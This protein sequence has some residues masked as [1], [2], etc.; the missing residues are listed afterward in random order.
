SAVGERARQKALHAF[1]PRLELAGH[2]VAGYARDRFGNLVQGQPAARRAGN[3][4]PTVAQLEVA[5]VHLQQVRGN[6]ERLL[7]HLSG[8]EMHRGTRGNSL[9]AGEAALAIGDD[10]G[11]AGNDADGVR[12]DPEL[13]GANLGKRGLDP[14]P[15]GHRAGVDGD[16]SRAADAHDAGFERAAACSLGAVADADAE[17]AAARSISTLALDK[18]GIVDRVKRGALVAREV[19]AVERDRR[20]GAGLE[21]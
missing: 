15:H 11:V 3:F 18:T 9:T 6:L 8:G 13:L 1:E 5:H 17:I 16:A 10:G 20:A 7:A 12:R 21:R 4:D 19:T 2:G 14:L